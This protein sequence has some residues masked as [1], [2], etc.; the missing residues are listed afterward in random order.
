MQQSTTVLVVEDDEDIR[1]MLIYSLQA[2]GLTTYDAMDAAAGWEILLNETVDLV[3]LDWMLPGMSGLELLRNLRRDQKLSELPV[4]MLTARGHEQDR[5][6]GLELGADDY[7]VK[8]YSMKEVMARISAVMRRSSSSSTDKV[9]E[10]NGL[11]FDLASHRVM[12]NGVVIDLG[13]TE[14]RI[15]KFFMEN[16]ERVYSRGQILD[17]AWPDNV[18]VEERTVDVHIR[19]LRKALEESK[20]EKMIQTVRGAGYRFSP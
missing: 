16:P 2:E 6:R 12:A 15:L 20:H 14:Y 13:P 9:L 8:P 7:I 3:L 10:Y 1:E 4:I 19:R 18:F 5:V 11:E 17:N